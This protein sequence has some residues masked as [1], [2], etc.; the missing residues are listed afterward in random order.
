LVAEASDIAGTQNRT[1]ANSNADLMQGDL[2][3]GA[4]IVMDSAGFDYEGFRQSSSEGK[5][6]LL[7]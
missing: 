1:T 3:K 7:L 5:G 4:A 6:W 2:E